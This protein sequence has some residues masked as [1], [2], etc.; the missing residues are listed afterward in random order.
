[1]SSMELK[2]R[3]G[4]PSEYQIVVD[5]VELNSEGGENNNKNE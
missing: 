4:K 3:C 2:S 1:M 5:N